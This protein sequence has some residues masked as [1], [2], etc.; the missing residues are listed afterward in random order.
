MAKKTAKP[1]ER[2]SRNSRFSGRREAAP[3][4]IVTRNG[5]KSSAPLVASVRVKF[6]ELRSCMCRWPIGDPRH[7]ETFRFCGCACPFDAA[8][9]K[10][11][12]AIAHSS[13][14]PKTPHWTKFKMRSPVGV[15][16]P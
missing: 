13:I 10:K 14:R 15:A 6:M 12:D 2:P 9:C 3:H 16:R 7:V 1:I 11:H 5:R 4:L 8:Y